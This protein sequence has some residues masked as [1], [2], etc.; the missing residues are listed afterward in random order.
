MAR[1]KEKH[2]ISSDY[3][4]F[5]IFQLQFLV[6]VQWPPSKMQNKD[7]FQVPKVRNKEQGVRIVFTC[8]KIEH[9]FFIVWNPFIYVPVSRLPV[10]I[11]NAGLH[12]TIQNDRRLTKNDTE[13]HAIYNID[14]YKTMQT[15]GDAQSTNVLSDNHKFWPH[16]VSSR[17][18]PVFGHF[19]YL[20]FR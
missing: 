13:N 1:K 14:A 5:N 6:Y 7:Q 10:I 19:N 16:L 4:S 15:I 20:L 12:Q 9:G 11:Q 18:T 8:R 3:K 17:K 2:H